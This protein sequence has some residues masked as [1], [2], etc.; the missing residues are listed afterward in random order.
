MSAGIAF[1]A[2]SLKLSTGSVFDWVEDL[3]QVREEREAAQ[4]EQRAREDEMEI[5]NFEAV[6]AYMVENNKTINELNVQQLKALVKW[7]K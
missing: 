3:L 1:N 7:F 2:R 5:K 6:K 4:V